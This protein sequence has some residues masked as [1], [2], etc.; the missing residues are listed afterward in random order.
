MAY[1]VSI[2][3]GTN[4]IE[5]ATQGF[6]TITLNGPAP[7]G[8]LTVNYGLAGTATTGVDYTLLA[9]S[10]ITNLTGSSFTI[11]AGQTSATVL[12]NANDDGIADP[13]E[14]VQLNILAG[15]GYSIYNAAQPFIAASPVSVG[16]APLDMAVGDFNG[17]GK[18]DLVTANSLDNTV[19][20]RLGDGLGGFG[21]STSLAMGTY[22]MGVVVGDF[23]GDGNVDIAT[24]N[25]N[26][27][28]ISVRLGN[29][30]GALA[31]SAIFSWGPPLVTWPWATLMAMAVLTWWPLPRLTPVS[32]F[33][34]G[35]GRGALVG[36]APSLQ[37]LTPTR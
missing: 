22:P 13:G 3:P 14:T 32:R 2:A 1:T 17:D 10:N 16:D 23:N 27:N 18:A 36:L 15:T 12:I 6:Y 35:M 25:L 7:I 31:T 28:N 34:W 33:C 19:S 5:G 21:G 26:S 4:P 37:A 29:G 11:A 24:A 30:L 8:G 20:I 9:G